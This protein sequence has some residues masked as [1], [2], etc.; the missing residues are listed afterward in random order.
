MRL[1]DYLTLAGHGTHRGYEAAS[2]LF[3]AASVT[4]LCFSGAILTTIHGEKAEPC[5]LSVTAPSYLA[6]T[7]QSVQDFR[8][9]DNVLDATGIVEVPVTA[10]SGKYSAGLILVGIDGEYLNDLV[11]TTGEL[12]PAGGAMPWITLS[13]AAAQSFTDPTDKTKHSASYMPDI[14]WLGADLSLDMGSSIISARVC[15]LFEGDDPAAY[16]GLDIAKTLLQSQ[17]QTAGF[18]GARVRITNIGAA[19]DVSKAITDLGY[20]VENRDSARQEKWDAQTR[21][22]VYLAILGAAGLLCAG[23]T[24]RTGAALCREETRCRD[25]VLRWAGMSNA[26]IRGIAVLRCIYLSLLGAGIGIAA[27]YLIAALVGLGDTA[28]VYALA[29]PPKWIL[30]PLCVCAAAGTFNGKE[31]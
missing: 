6:I 31:T 13:E 19:E 28:S 16:I 4:A 3:M 1:R 20:Q 5:E 27:H 11:Y 17:G 14:D 22:A 7:E 2:V 26:A 9:I 24:R 21:E 23:M 10:S 18:T 12:F 29:L 30:I 8:A 15:G 25:D